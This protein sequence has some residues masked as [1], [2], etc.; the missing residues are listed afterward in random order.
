MSLGMRD[1]VG[2]WDAM[3]TRVESGNL[4]LGNDLSE[5]GK[6]HEV[7]FLVGTGCHQRSWLSGRLLT[8]EL[9]PESTS[10]NRLFEPPPGSGEAAIATVRSSDSFE[11]HRAPL[12]IADPNP[13][14]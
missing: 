14:S 1:P 7:S 8:A 13:P 6:C 9:L 3:G 12:L 2:T 10:Q 5:H 11:D 4:V